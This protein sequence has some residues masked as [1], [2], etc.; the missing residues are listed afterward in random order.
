[1]WPGFWSKQFCSPRAENPGNVLS[2]KVHNI[3]PIIFFQVKGISSTT[4]VTLT[5]YQNPL[6]TRDYIKS[7]FADQLDRH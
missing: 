4:Q 6:V 5:L 7:Q 1:M 3:A 2:V